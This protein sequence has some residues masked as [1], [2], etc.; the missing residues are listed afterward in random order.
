MEKYAKIIDEETKE[1]QIGVGCDDE[2][3]IKIG[4][5]LMNV[6]Q[7][8]N[9]KWYVAGYEPVKPEPTEDDLKIWV[10]ATR[11]SFLLDTDYTQLNDAPFNAYEKQSYAEYRQYL[12][13][14]TN[15]DLWWLNDPK[16]YSEWKKG[17]S[18]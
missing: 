15:Q 5:T 3:Y 10:R 12:R 14:Y 9:A 7:A 8:Y 2:Y 1:V 17:Q 16:T 11:N 6:V 13:D 4:M 18:A